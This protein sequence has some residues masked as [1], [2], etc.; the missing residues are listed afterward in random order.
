VQKIS[1]TF[2]DFTNERN[3]KISAKELLISDL[4]FQYT[5]PD[6]NHE[7]YLITGKYLKPIQDQSVILKKNHNRYLWLQLHIIEKMPKGKF[8]GEFVFHQGEQLTKIPIEIDN[9]SYTLPKVEFPVGFFGI[10]P[11]PFSYFP[12]KGYNQLRKT[13]RYLALDAIGEAGFTTF[14]GL[15]ESTDDL[16][17]LFERSSKWGIQT[18]YS[19]GGQFPQALVDLSKK[20]DLSDEKYLEK[21][22]LDLKPLLAK[23]DWP[24]I[25][26]T[27]SDEAAGY[28][29]KV[30][31]DIELAKKL[32]KYLPFMALGGFGTFNGG[33]TEKLNSFFDYGFYSTLDKKQIA[34]IKDNNQ[35]WGLYNGSPGNLDDPRFS[36][37][38]GLYI[39]RLN[40]LSQYLE[41]HLSAVNNYP[42]FD[43]DGRESDVVMFFPRSDGSL[44]PSLR[45]E[46]AVQG[47]HAFKKLKLLETAISNNS[48]NLAALPAAKGWLDKLKKENY[49]FSSPNFISNKNVN[50][51]EF[52]LQLNDHL[53][54][55]FLK[56]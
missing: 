33:D 2:S 43:F 40:G 13:Y 6:I 5:S 8:T 53:K 3:E 48:G 24:K 11:L 22:A 10:D 21:V 36:F 18:V 38:L 23:K 12:G 41:W 27:F 46:M 19:Y 28:S 4:I 20:G 30:S 51:H 17:E 42:Y 49:F 9:L 47:L 14:T 52:D 15:P 32:K 26:H 7:T 35:R 45:F 56:K 54:K 55:I 25:V 34:K 1:W 37:G 16:N 31:S 39:A 44:L 50:F 29:D